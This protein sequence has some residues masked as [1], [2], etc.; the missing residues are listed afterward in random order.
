[1]TPEAVLQAK[2]AISD[3][4]YELQKNIDYFSRKE[5]ECRAEA[6]KYHTLLQKVMTRQNSLIQSLE[7]LT[8]EFGEEVEEDLDGD[9]GRSYLSTF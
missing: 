8:K 2:A 3:E 9:P 6:E 4:V 1:M 7:G 5:E